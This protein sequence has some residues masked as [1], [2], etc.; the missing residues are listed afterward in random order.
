VSADA[1]V[2]LLDNPEDLLDVLIAVALCGLVVW[3]LTGVMRLRRELK[4]QRGYR[5][6]TIMAVL[7]GSVAA[8]QVLTVVNTILIAYDRFSTIQVRVFILLT[9]E[10]IEVLAVLWT[11]FAVRSLV[12][13]GANQRKRD[14]ET[15]AAR[16][17]AEDEPGDEGK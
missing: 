15:G 6:T 11:V 14:E 4:G 8:A 16:Q 2:R 12:I 10:T 13:D 9:S 17:R 5:L 7:I 3:G 1:L